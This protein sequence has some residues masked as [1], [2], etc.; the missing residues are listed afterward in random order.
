MTGGGNLKDKS[1]FSRII[2]LIVLSLICFTI[3]IALTFFAGSYDGALFSFENL[4]IAN[5]IPVLLLSGFVSC[6]VIGITLLFIFRAAFIKLKDY[7]LENKNTNGGNK[8]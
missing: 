1:F 4:N 7:F 5:M 6:V 2:L 8:K 3:T